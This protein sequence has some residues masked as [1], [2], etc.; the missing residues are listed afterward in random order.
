MSYIEEI[1]PT[2]SIFKFKIGKEMCKLLL[3]QNP[4]IYIKWKKQLE[5]LFKL[6]LPE[7]VFLQIAGPYYKSIMLANWL[8]ESSITADKEKIDTILSKLKELKKLFKYTEMTP[9][10]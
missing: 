3:E 7:I 10:V 9:A 1:I 5:V 6:E 8:K 4:E 2:D